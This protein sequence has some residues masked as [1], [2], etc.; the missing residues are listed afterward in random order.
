MEYFKYHGIKHS[1]SHN[2]DFSVLEYR[3]MFPNKIPYMYC[4]CCNKPI[5]RR[6]IVL[7]NPET[8]VEE[9]YL[10]YTCAKNFVNI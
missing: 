8:D 4:D 5:K 7:Q 10:G 2:K 1:N 6:M 3:E 9:Y